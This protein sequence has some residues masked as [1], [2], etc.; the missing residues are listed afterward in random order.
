MLSAIEEVA[1]TWATVLVYEI[2]GEV[3]RYWKCVR[4]ATELACCGEW[5]V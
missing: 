1:S 2:P 5:N 4:V 3:G